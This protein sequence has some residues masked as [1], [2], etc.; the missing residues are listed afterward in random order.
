MKIPLKTRLR[1]WWEGYEA[2]DLTR[3]N[4]PAQASSSTEASKSLVEP[5][6][7]WETPEIR[8]VQ[9]IWG[10]GYHKPGGP[11]YILGLVKPFGLDPSKSMMEFGS[12]LGGAARTIANEYGVWIT[13]YEQD[14][15]F[16]RA[17]KQMSVMAGLEKKADILRYFPDDFE[18]HANMFDCIL[19]SETLFRIADKYN[20][21]E[22][23]QRGLKVRGQLTIT[24]FVL[25]DGIAPTDPRLQNLGPETLHFW[26]IGQY[27]QRFREL[28]LDLRVTEDITETY[29]KMILNG[30]ANFAQG[31]PA[32]FATARAYPTVIV[33][34]L[35]TWT[36]RMQALE[37]GLLKVVRFY[38][39]RK[40]TTKLMSDW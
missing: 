33:S 4:Q 32:A 40:S 28:N 8:M 17:G 29:R 14:V 11:D 20:L 26:E 34:E 24:D 36:S 9:L 23:L 22:K 2:D 19:S 39:I 27:E 10:T 5:L 38:A 3:L 16:A 35:N 25:G 6:A 7:P 30:W 37:S 12:G 1:A 21:L 18:L 31:D 15:Q 13:G